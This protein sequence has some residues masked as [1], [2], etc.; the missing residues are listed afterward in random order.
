MKEFKGKTA[1]ITG[2][3]SGLGLGI[4][5]ACAGEGMNVVIAD[6]RQSV[7]DQ[8]VEVFNK[9]N[10]PV[11][12]IQ[13]DTSKLDQY[14]K[15]VAKAEAQFGNI[16]LL[17]NNAGITC[18]AGPLHEVS[19]KDID[20]GINVN[21]WG[22]ING[23]KL[24]LPHMLSHGEESHIVSTASMSG[25]IPTAKCDI[26]NITKGAVVA[27]TESLGAALIGTNVGI[28]VFC[29]GP[30]DTKLG[31]N[32]EEV[33]AALLGSKVEKA[34]PTESSILPD[35]DNSVTRSPSE[36]GARVI[37]GIKR[38]DI[39]IFTH[40]EFKPGLTERWDAIMK[41]LP[42]EAPDMRFY[43]E[44]AFLATNPIYQYQAQ[45]PALEK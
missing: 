34:A 30:H 27:L 22:V 38:K 11:L 39:Y 10:W 14:E 37:R 8:T 2:G 28:S 23:V 18:T 21:L 40:C 6:L 20:I 26:Y 29:P 25:L 45:V 36:A 41:A 44:F 4:A 15:A 13:L 9:N 42:D 35:Y 32:S 16:H 5:K 7:L 3:A 24:I 1:F 17:V 12:G 43:K 31:A 33:Q 19:F